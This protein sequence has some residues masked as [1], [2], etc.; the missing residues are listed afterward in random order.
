MN[1]SLSYGQ[2]ASPNNAVDAV[3]LMPAGYVAP[4]DADAP[5]IVLAIAEYAA[6]PGPGSDPT[7]LSEEIAGGDG[8]E[9][10]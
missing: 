5:A 3:A 4:A 10:A 6:N 2:I 9:G 1:L 7:T 8:G